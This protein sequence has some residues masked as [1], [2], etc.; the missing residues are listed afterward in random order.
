[1]KYKRILVLIEKKASSWL[2]EINYKGSALCFVNPPEK[3]VFFKEIIQYNKYCIY[4][5]ASKAK[6]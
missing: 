4:I 6:L 1:M 5:N 2:S 3:L